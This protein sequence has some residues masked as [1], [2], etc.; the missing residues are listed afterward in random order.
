[1]NCLK[2]LYEMNIL[3]S[4]SINDIM[5]ADDLCLYCGLEVV[6]DNELWFVRFATIFNTPIEL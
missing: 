6:E 2:Y 3:I 4:L 5:M 1:M